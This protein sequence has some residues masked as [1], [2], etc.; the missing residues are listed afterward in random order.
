[1]RKNFF[2]GFHDIPR[3]CVYIYDSNQKGN[4]SAVG[5]VWNDNV[6]SDGIRDL[7]PEEL[8]TVYRLV[9]TLIPNFFLKSELF[10]VN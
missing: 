1:M 9:C 3:S 7:S 8:E 5:T 10:Q 4:E 6:L 2:I